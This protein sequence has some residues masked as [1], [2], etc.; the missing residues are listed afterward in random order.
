MIEYE[1]ESVY[2]VVND[3]SKKKTISSNIQTL[4]P[5]VNKVNYN[6]SVNK[7]IINQKTNQILISENTLP[8]SYLPEKVNKLIVSDQ[9]TYLPLATT[10]KKVTYNKAKPIIHESKIYIKEGD[11]NILNNLNNLYK[12]N[13]NY[14]DSKNLLNNQNNDYTY[15]TYN[16]YNNNIGNNYN[17]NYIMNNNENYTMNANSQLINNNVTT[18]RLENNQRYNNFQT[19]T[20]TTPSIQTQNIQYCI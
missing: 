15:L 12:I 2:K 17:Y 9:V 7:A 10:E 18:K 16:N 5:I 3:I 8:V 6:V 4:E 20:Q 13:N 11:E 19:T 1:R 14:N